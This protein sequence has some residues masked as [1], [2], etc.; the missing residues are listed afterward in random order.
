MKIIGIFTIKKQK[1]K[2][3]E[4]D[5]SPYP[6]LSSSISGIPYTLYSFLYKYNALISRQRLE[7]KS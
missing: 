1:Q 4:I 2:I 6:I 7:S 3:H 5:E